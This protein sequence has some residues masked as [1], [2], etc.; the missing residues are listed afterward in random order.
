MIDTDTA[1]SALAAAFWE[2]FQATGEVDRPAIRRLAERALGQGEAHDEA[3]R[4]LFGRIVE[5]LADAFDR[6]AA[7]A[8]VDLFAEVLAVVRR[9][10]AGAELDRELAALGLAPESIAPRGHRLLAD[11]APPPIEGARLAIVLPK[12]TLGAEVAMSTPIIA[13]LLESDP[14][15]RLV[16]VAAA[17]ARGF[18]AGNPRVTFR[19]IAYPRRGG[20]L[21]RLGCWLRLCEIVRQESAGLPPRD[22]VVVDPDSRLTQTGLMPVAPD[23]QVRYFPSRTIE[24]EGLERLSELAAHWAQALTRLPEPPRPRLWLRDAACEWAAAVRARLAPHGR[25]WVVV[26]LGVGGNPLKGLGP[27]FDERLVR[28]LIARGLGVLLTRGVADDEVA[29]VA[30]LSARL[31]AGGIDARDLPTDGPL[32]AL[33]APG[34]QLVTWQE[35]TSRWAAL[36][37]SA[38]LHVGYD[39]AGQHVAAAVGTP[40]LTVF[41]PTG[42]E[43]FVKRWSPGGRGATRIVQPAPGRDPEALAGEAVDAAWSL[44]SLR[45]G[46]AA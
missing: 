13:A 40:G 6:R 18:V 23:D 42:G 43:R 37:A 12:W 36:I 15:R 9:D 29:N 41:V 34:A 16:F 11:A 26:N 28:G 19:E 7:H 44:M 21:A 4:A 32:S 33:D 8:Y 22:W 2:R 17:A 38:D 25:R 20:L 27:A 1:P 39:S 45:A 3:A 24:V 30:A 31:A 5:P 14:D 46:G 10:P 35:E